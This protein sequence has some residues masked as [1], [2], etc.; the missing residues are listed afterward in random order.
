MCRVNASGGR[1]AG[2]R[3]C[4][5][6]PRAGTGGTGWMGTDAGGWR[7][8]WTTRAWIRCSRRDEVRE[9]EAFVG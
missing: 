4:E 1:D 9:G 2:A 5:D 8:T 7:W 3:A 6:A